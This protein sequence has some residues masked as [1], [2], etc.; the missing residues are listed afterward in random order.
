[1]RA[2]VQ[3]LV[4]QECEGQRKVTSGALLPARADSAC[5]SLLSKHALTLFT[6]SH[7]LSI[8]RT[9]RLAK[10]FPKLHFRDGNGY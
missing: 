5:I 8:S 10:F 1:M 2:R 9:P 7:H 6:P 4:V 3:W